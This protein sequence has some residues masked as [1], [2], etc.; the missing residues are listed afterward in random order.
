LA[1]GSL[2][3][4]LAS[5]CNASIYGAQYVLELLLFFIT[6]ISRVGKRTH[7]ITPGSDCGP[8][9]VVIKVTLVGLPAGVRCI[10]PLEHTVYSHIP[11]EVFNTLRTNK[12]IE[13]K[14]Y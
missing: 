10:C 2:K 13:T 14:T 11:Q 6:A 12:K 3:Q 1:A 9:L 5:P 7:H 4:S 8:E